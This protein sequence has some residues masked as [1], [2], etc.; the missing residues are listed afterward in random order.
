MGS[1]I[2][3]CVMCNQELLTVE[4]KKEVLDAAERLIDAAEPWQEDQDAVVK[5]G[6]DL[7]QA[8]VKLRNLRAQIAQSEAAEEGDDAVS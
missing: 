5:C 1:M 7:R 6:A 2:T 4:A 8:V 3:K